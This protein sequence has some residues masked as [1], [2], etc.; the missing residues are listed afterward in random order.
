M[1]FKLNNMKKLLTL[2]V[3][4]LITLSAY[5]QTVRD[6]ARVKMIHGD[7]TST[8]ALIAIKNYMIAGLGSGSVTSVAVT[9]PAGL[10]V[11]GSP[12]TT[13]GTFAFSL[14]NDLAAVEG[15][16][17]TG[18]VRRTGTDT[19]T[20]GTTVAATEGGTGQTSYAI[21]DLLFAS[22]TTALSKLADVAAGQPLL[23][24]GVN[25]APAY[26]GYTFSG[27]GAQTYTFPTTS[28]TL[29]ATDFSNSSTG[30]ANQILGT[31]N[32]GTATE[33]KTVSVGSTGTDFN[34]VLSGANAIVVHLPDAGA[35][36]RGAVTTAAQTIA[37]LKTFSGGTVHT[38]AASVAAVKSDGVTQKGVTAF[39]SGPQTLSGVHSEV[40]VT[41]S[42]VSITINLPAPAAG[43]NG[44]TYTI[45]KEDAT[46]H[47]IVVAGTF[48]TGTQRVLAG[49]GTS[50]VVQSNATNWR[51]IN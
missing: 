31:N 51:V 15:L 5:S 29:M 10:S 44:W 16:A 45:N 8:Q 21:G 27:T 7:T 20:A 13:S 22:T 25:T 24:G 48:N 43:N 47:F 28:K 49:Q 19:W 18:I 35:S 34:V 41:C 36:A 6:S 14:A 50:V 17:T 39:S 32:A 42:T 4:S 2:L 37:G 38:G 11:T 12:I 9:V 46:A 23:S 40:N 1:V 33:W 30:T 26:A 3:L